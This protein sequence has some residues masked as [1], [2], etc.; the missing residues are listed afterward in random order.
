[1]DNKNKPMGLAIG[2][3]CNGKVPVRWMFHQKEQV[4]PFLPGGLYWTYIFATGDFTR[5]PEKSYASLRNDIVNKA[6]AGNYKWLLFI[7]DDVFLPLRLPNKE[8]SGKTTVI[9]SIAVIVNTATSGAYITNVIL[10]SNDVDGSYTAQ[11]TYATDIGNGS[12]GDVNQEILTT[13]YEMVDYP[14]YIRFDL[15]GMV[16]VT[17]I[18]IRG[19]K[20][21]YHHKADE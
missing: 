14:H 7:D 10:E 5:E 16:A 1:M 17:D 9:D 20:V 18:K 15:A 21:K 2:I 6:L 13:P 8:E 12:T 3:I 4:E 11:V 19:I